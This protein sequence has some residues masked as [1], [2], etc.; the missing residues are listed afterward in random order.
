ME[1]EGRE[2]QEISAERRGD[3]RVRVP[4]SS[5]CKFYCASQVPFAPSR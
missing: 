2:E 3:E 4:S 1:V 5:G